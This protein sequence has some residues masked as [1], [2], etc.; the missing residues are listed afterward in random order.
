MRNKPSVSQGWVPIA[1]YALL[2]VVVTWPLVLHLAGSLTY[3]G[4]LV[5]TVPLFNLWTMQ[6][7]QIQIGDLYSNYWNAP[8]FHPTAGTFALSEPQPLTGLAFAPVS[9]LSGNP[10]LGYNVVSLVILTLNGYAGSRL[11]RVLGAAAGP[12]LLVGAMAVGLPFVSHQLGVLQ[13][14]VVF[15]ILLLIEAVLR[16]A[17]RDGAGPAARAGL[18]LAVTFLTCGYYGLFAIVA[19]GL[20]TPV[21]A[22]REWLS[23]RRLADLAVAGGVFGVLALPVLLGQV[24]YT[25][26]FERSDDLIRELSAGLGDYFRL[27]PHALGA[28][29][30]PWL[31]DSSAGHGLYPGTVLIVLALAGLWFGLR[32]GQGAESV[33][34]RRRPW[35]LFLGVCAAGLLSGGLKLSVLGFHP[36]DVVRAVVPGYEQLR[37]PS[38]FAVLG[39]LFL[40]GLAAYGL[41]ALWRRV[42]LGP[43]L[44]VALVALGMAEVS[45]VPV[46]L[47]RPQTHT[48]WADWLKHRGDHPVVALV[49]FPPSGRV[50]E[51]QP[52][53][54]GMVALSGTGVTMVNGYSGLFPDAYEYLS[55][56]MYGYPRRSADGVLRRYGVRYLVVS[57]RWM[58]R[59]PSRARRL[60]RDHRRVYADGEATIFAL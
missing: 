57:T 44:A 5:R 55:N 27:D 58:N 32:R 25:S 49:P 22:R 9:A 50:V 15:P 35:F 6:W 10:V 51:F 8:I 46:R 14:T 60:A 54:A 52:T 13:L 16:W 40:L 29:V 36:Y 20:V 28:G 4:E 34:E 48:A 1:V 39:E 47:F 30:A 23:W 31:H 43:I 3:G 11:A 24:K 41:D 53:A 56:V 19:I 59:V 12:A 37:T 33:D 45:L 42:R 21:L 18:W 2:S 17:P 26:G 7:N 38:R